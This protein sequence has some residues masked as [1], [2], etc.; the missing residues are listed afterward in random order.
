MSISFANSRYSSIFI[1]LGSILTFVV[2]SSNI[3]QSQSPV[4]QHLDSRDGLSQN[5]VVS[6]DQ[7]DR[8]F[9]WIGTP[10]GLNRYD[11]RTF[12]VYHH[13]PKNSGSLSS[14][15]VSCTQ[16]D[17]NQTLWVGT[18][19]GLNKYNP[20]T[21]SFQQIFHNPADQRSL[22]HDQITCMLRDH[23]GTIWV[24][25]SAG[26]NQLIDPTTNRFK[27]YT[28][29]D[30][31]NHINS[32]CQDQHG[33]LWLGT[34]NGL[35]RMTTGGTQYKV[36][37]QNTSAPNCLRDNS[38]AALTIDS[39]QS[40]WIGTKHGELDRLNLTDESFSHFRQS[41][42]GLSSNSQDEI[43]CLFT[44]RSDKLW[45]GTPEGLVSLETK[46]LQVTH[47]QNDADDPKSLSDNNV[48]C[49]F[50]DRLG[51]LW[52]GT[53]YSGVNILH[54]DNTPFKLINHKAVGFKTINQI[55]EDHKHNLWIGSDGAGLA[56]LDRRTGTIIH[57]SAGAD[58]KKSLPSLQTKTIYIDKANYTWVGMR[59]G[60]ISRLD[61]AHKEW[62]S[63]RHDSQDSS[64]INSDNVYALLEDSQQRLWVLTDKGIRVFTN[65]QGILKP[66]KL[67]S[68]LAKQIDTL[69]CVSILE[70]QWHNKWVGRNGGIYI[71][72]DSSDQL[73]WLP[74]KK[75]STTPS[76][77]IFTIHQDQLGRIWVGT[78]KDGLKRFDEGQRKFID[79][80][81]ADGLQAKKILAI[82]SDKMGILWLATEHGL[83][84][85]DPDRKQSLLYTATDGIIGSEFEPNSSFKGHDSTLYFGTNNGLIYFNPYA[86]HINEQAPTT[87][88]TSLEVLN[89]PVKTG[90]D[91]NLLDSD[92]SL[93][94]KLTFTH[95]QNFFT[96]TF[97]VLNYIKPEKNQFAYKLDDIDTDWHYIQTPSITFT[98]LP[99]GHY[100]LLVKGA[101]NDGIWSKK[102]A[103]IGIVILPPFW[104]TWWAICCYFLAGFTILYFILR[105]FWIRATIQREQELHRAKLDFFTNISHEIRTHLT[106]IIGP[107]DLLLHTKKEDKDVQ[108]QLTY[109]KNSSTSLLKLVTELLDFRKAEAKKLPLHIAQIEL[110]SFIKNILHSF[111]YESKKRSIHLSFTSNST[112][113]RL[114]FDPDQFSKVI[115]NLLANAF[116]FIQDGGAIAV[117]VHEDL[118][119]VKIT[120]SDNG[121]GISAENIK[122]LFVNYF[123]VYDFNSQ[124][125]GY[126]IGLA[127]AKTITELHNGTLTVES[128]EA[129]PGVPGYTCFSIVLLKGDKHFDKEPSASPSARSDSQVKKPS[130]RIS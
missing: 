41:I 124:N 79:Y 22:S 57:Y 23:R 38:V 90:D 9:I 76:Q 25:T 24:G 55:A 10:E 4:F 85:F 100:T 95:Q 75:N 72:N 48:F 2:L 109:A 13:D 126:G 52:F 5:T 130:P 65:R 114:W 89:K 84:R 122:K 37:R 125:T 16:N 66:F 21:D 7:D 60:G 1:L 128:Q 94:D 11:S 34:D 74:F 77:Y 8:G 91:S 18:H 107:I 87:V 93:T 53:Y 63:F 68:P 123:Q 14:D 117:N 26:L 78:R 99:V 43:F 98:N 56:Y 118:N 29:P 83:V 127:L 51:S 110:I 108:T 119:V 101:N 96:L 42:S 104:K 58:P 28:F 40:L 113:I 97:A 64:S 103:Q 71:I 62:G 19:N 102:P 82:E 116:K 86:I 30:S 47:Y 46:S 32:I 59:R 15:W 88:F 20:K 67:N 61:P 70:D 45:V 105:S 111:Q 6:V 54:P 33:N 35:V 27:R 106:L 12:R 115:Y 44:D 120:I 112:A 50:Q 80:T 121:K 3:C 49:I 17:S 36:F 81:E 31:T 129:K 39:H 73:R 92:I 69:R